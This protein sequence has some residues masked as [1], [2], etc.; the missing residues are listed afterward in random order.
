MSP[1][2]AFAIWR[3][4]QIPRRKIPLQWQV[5]KAE[6]L[7]SGGYQQSTVVNQGCLEFAE[8]KIAP[9]AG[10]GQCGEKIAGINIASAVGLYLKG[11]AP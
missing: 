11:D 8:R 3:K 4:L 10:G 2:E 9:P 7:V 5:G 1:D 6:G